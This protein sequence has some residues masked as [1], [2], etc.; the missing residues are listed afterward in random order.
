M[1]SVRNI[2]KFLDTSNLPAEEKAAII[3][4]ATDKAKDNIISFDDLDYVLG[5]HADNF[6]AQ[7][8]SP[9]QLDL[10]REDLKKFL[11]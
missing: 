5:R 4:R 6:R 9:E 7:S 3:K 2:G 1:Y 8:I 11:R 10:A